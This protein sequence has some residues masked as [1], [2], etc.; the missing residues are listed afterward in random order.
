M[1]RDVDVNAAW[2]IARRVHRIIRNI[3]EF[4]PKNPP[5]DEKGKPFKTPNRY[6][7]QAEWLKMV[8]K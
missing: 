1:P 2:N 4:D 3:R 5:L 6:I 7:S 8:T